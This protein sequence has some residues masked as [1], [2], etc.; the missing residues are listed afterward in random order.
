MMVSDAG[1]TTTDRRE[2]VTTMTKPTTMTAGGSTG[3]S[4]VSEGGSGG[5][6]AEMVAFLSG[7]GANGLLPPTHAEGPRS[8]AWTSTLAGGKGYRRSLHG[9]TSQRIAGIRGASAPVL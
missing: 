8:M 6:F 4:P 9:V 1:P 5:N 2:E 3:S 7:P